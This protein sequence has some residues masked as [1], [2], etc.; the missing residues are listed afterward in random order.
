ML[1]GGRLVLGWWYSTGGGLVPVTAWQM[2]YHTCKAKARSQQYVERVSIQDARPL[3]APR[4]WRLE[5]QC[6]GWCMTGGRL[7]DA[8]RLPH[9]TSC[10]PLPHHCS[11]PPPTFGAVLLLLWSHQRLQEQMVAMPRATRRTR[12]TGA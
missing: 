5:A 3:L 8:W 9:S 1:S 6:N 12:A 7:L 4:C 2:R 10:A 11:R